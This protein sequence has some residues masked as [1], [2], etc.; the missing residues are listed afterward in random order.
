MGCTIGAREALVTWSGHGGAMALLFALASVIVGLG[1]IALRRH[2]GLSRAAHNSARDVELLLKLTVDESSDL[3]A[4]MKSFDDAR[5]YVSRS[6]RS[7][8]G[9]DS[10]DFA[11]RP[12]PDFIHP[13]DVDGVK[14]QYAGLSPASPQVTSVHRLRHKAGHYLWVESLFRLADGPDP[15]VIVTT[16]DITGRVQA[17]QA[18]RESD[19]RFHLLADAATDVV[20]R[21]DLDARYTYVSP[22]ALDVLGY[23]PDQMIGRNLADFAN[24][25]DAK[26][27]GALFARMAAGSSD[28][29]QNVHRMTHANGYPI[30]VEVRLRL[31]RDPNTG[32]PSEVVSSVCDVTE[33]EAL[34]CRLEESNRQL[35]LS[36]EIAHVGHWRLERRTNWSTC[37]E[38][39]YRICGFN[40]D[41]RPL[42]RENILDFFHPED[43]DVVNMM[44]A[45]VTSQKRAYTSKVRVLRPD[46]EIRHVLCRGV[47]EYDG[48][49]AEV[50]GVFGAL[51][52]I[53]ELTRAERR[54]R[55]ESALL[56]A[57]LD[58][59][60]QGLIKLDREGAIELV[61]QR[62]FELLKLPT[63]LIDDLGPNLK[64]I[65]AGMNISGDE[66]RRRVLRRETETTACLPLGTF[67][68]CP[69]SETFLEVRTTPG[70]GNSVVST[71]T[72]ITARRHAE[73][74][75]RSSEVRYRALI[76]MTSDVISQLDADLS[77]DYVSPS[78]R[79]VLGYEPEEILGP[80]FYRIIHPDDVEN[81]KVLMLRLVQGETKDDRTM[82]TFRSLH[83]EGGAIWLEAA[84]SL[85]RDEGS[86]EPQTI[87]CSMRD[88]TYRQLAAEHLER[89]RIAA[90][91]AAT[92]KADF[93]ANM[94]HEL[95]TPLTGILGVHDLLQS[96]P[97]LTAAQRRLIG[98]ASTS[99]R[100]LLTIVND[101]LDF[102]K[103][104]AGHLN[105]ESIPFDFR[106]L[107]EHCR[108]MAARTAASKPVSVSAR[109]SRSPPD[110]IVGDPTRVQQVLTNLLNNAVKFTERGSIAIEVS[111]HAPT[112]TLRVEVADT[113]LGVPAGNM[114]HLFDRFSQVDEST[115]RR[116]G[117]TGLG[118]AI[119]KRLVELM[120]GRIG[121]ESEL[122][123]GS[124]FWFELPLTEEAIR[125]VTPKNAPREDR[126]RNLSILLAEDNLVNQEIIE[127]MLVSRGHRVTLVEDGSAAV[128]AFSEHDPFD[129][130][131]M[132]LQMPGMDGLAATT[133]I[134]QL[135]QVSG[136]ARI[137]II[138]LTANAMPQDVERCMAAGMDGHVAKPVDWPILFGRID[139]LPRQLEDMMAV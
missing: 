30:W 134:R 17:E 93:V 95:R 52:D 106:Q 102:S 2:S 130:I 23:L 98:M 79:S 13:D 54:T 91:Q 81:V 113:G 100:S 90:E 82:A 37:S 18:A 49:D 104:E 111:Y 114:P 71:V 89:A 112:R 126:Q 47:C 32:R 78:S 133:A 88:V 42:G 127:A 101:I 35:L 122:G 11:L 97:T 69:D 80:D 28:H 94:S 12:L 57:T 66:P 123:R 75:M 8:L 117:G 83:K 63:S 92:A 74:A 121:V 124:R 131:L 25:S 33:R 107:V 103:I 58:T 70:L 48:D 67:E 31:I 20:S 129:L 110:W 135:E 16:R 41:E 51:L 68:Y 120:N 53:T 39:V 96:D 59:M 4:M 115:A 105:V 108:D 118:L 26:V 29:A 43:R 34:R 119:C 73:I 65:R 40:P 45:D 64:Q 27:L 10:R 109:F 3:I 21:I 50:R 6:S 5:A 9:W 76:N 46:G 1:C 84:M 128:D 44:I 125:S 55:K 14:S 15:V 72:N 138:G 116:F 60:D 137:P 36:E 85:V 56:E 24:P 19:M 136:R 61:N 86:G 7:M 77:C 132:D 38:E 99:G 62:F 139:D 87:I 22:A